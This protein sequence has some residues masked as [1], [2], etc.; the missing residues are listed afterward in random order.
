MA[1]DYFTIAL[2]PAG[3]SATSRVLLGGA[4][5]IGTREDLREALLEL[6][7]GDPGPRITV[8][9]RQVTFIDSEAINALIEGYLAAERAGVVFRLAGARG[10]VDRVLRV[11]GLDHL[12]DPPETGGD[13]AD[14]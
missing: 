9:L 12:L 13:P 3:G 1:D 2:E 10:I 8:D 7:G 5:D 4:F 14:G 11:I 6:V